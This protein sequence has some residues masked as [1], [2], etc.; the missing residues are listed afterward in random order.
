LDQYIIKIA[1]IAISPFFVENIQQI[2]LSAI[3][4]ATVLFSKYPDHRRSL[5][6]D[7]LSS[8]AR[9]PTTKRNLR[10]YRLSHLMEEDDD[11]VMCIQIRL[12]YKQLSC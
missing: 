10:N 1:S 5:L 8:L 11:E 6:D 9:L 4:C 2:Q 12:S 3:K 7:I